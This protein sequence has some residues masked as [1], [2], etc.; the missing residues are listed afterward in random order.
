M[1]IKFGG[2]VIDRKVKQER[3]PSYSHQK[4]P[5]MS[6]LCFRG[7]CGFSPPGFF[8][9]QKAVLTGLSSNFKVFLYFSLFKK[10]LILLSGSESSIFSV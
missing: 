1:E 6:H 2:G 4:N 7:N 10:P 3:E 5:V 9:N 8:Q